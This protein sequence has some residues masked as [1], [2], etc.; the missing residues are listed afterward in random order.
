MARVSRDNDLAAT[1]HSCTA[2][3]GVIATCRT[4]Y[5]NSI[6]V[7][8]P[9]D[10][11]K[12]HT[13]YCGCPPCCCNHPATINVGSR[14]VFAEGIPVARVGDSADFGRMIQGSGNVY[15]GG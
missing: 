1:G 10:P 14:T 7:A 6:R 9:P 3:I 12:P 8:R 4:V 15:A 5:A 2:I 13:I 11:L